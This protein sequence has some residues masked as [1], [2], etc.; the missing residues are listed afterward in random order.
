MYLAAI[1][2]HAY[3]LDPGEEVTSLKQAKESPEWPEW[4]H[5]IKAE[6]DQLTMGT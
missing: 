4:E 1:K 5:A 6:L 3:T 2:E